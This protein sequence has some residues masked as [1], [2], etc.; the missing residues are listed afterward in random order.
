MLA[1]LCDNARLIKEN[2][3]QEVT[4]PIYFLGGIPTDDGLFSYRIFGK[5]SSTERRFTFAYIN[6]FRKFLHGAVYDAFK[7]IYRKFDELIDG[8]LQGYVNRDGEL[9]ID[10]QEKFPKGTQ[11]FYGIDGIISNFSKINFKVGRSNENNENVVFLSNLLAKEIYIETIVIIPAFFRDLQING[12]IASADE[13]S[14]LYKKLIGLTRGFEIKGDAF[15]FLTSKKSEL[16]VQTKIYEL[17]LLLTKKNSKKQGKIRQA[18]LGKAVDY[19][20]RPVISGSKVSANYFTEQ[21]VRYGEIGLPLHLLLYSFFPLINYQFIRFLEPVVF[22]NTIVIRSSKQDRHGQEV[23]Y[24]DKA[25]IESLNTKKVKK[26]IDMYARSE[27]NR[28]EPL[29]IMDDSGKLKEYADPLFLEQMGREFITLTDLLWLATAQAIY[30]NN[31]VF[32]SD[33]KKV[34]AADLYPAA[35]KYVLATRYPLEDYRNIAI[36]RPIILTTTKTRDIVSNDSDLFSKLTHESGSQVIFRG[37]PDLSPKNPRF[38]DSCRPHYA[39]LS[40]WGGDF[41]GD[42]ISIKSLF[43]NEANLEAGAIF[44]QKLNHLDVNNGFS[45]DFSKEALVSLFMLTR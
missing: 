2:D 41:D 3:L 18:L 32:V 23:I 8:T 42:M 27:A 11:S 10:L 5:E 22:S 13:I 16:I 37:Y 14:E 33:G 26:I 29:Y 6:L 20:V 39:Y 36:Q 44:N 21:E 34:Y 7:K 17:F 25:F 45:R 4:N 40:G 12:E 24:L 1:D 9:I 30:G 31:I 35:T 28:L 43:T 38:I 15:A 19:A